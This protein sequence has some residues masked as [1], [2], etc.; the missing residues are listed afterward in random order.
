MSNSVIKDRPTFDLLEYSKGDL[1]HH[2]EQS[3]LLLNKIFN[4]NCTQLDVIQ[5]DFH[6]DHIRPISSFK[7]TSADDED[8]KKCWALSNLQWLP[9][10][11]NMSKGN[12]WDGTEEN[13]TYRYGPVLTTTK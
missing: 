5:D 9:A 4:L 3:R 8:F 13:L 12:L 6:I 7:Y 2:L 11:V 10:D 1:L